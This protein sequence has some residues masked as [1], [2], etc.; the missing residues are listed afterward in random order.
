MAHNLSSLGILMV[1]MTGS[2]QAFAAPTTTDV[3]ASAGA[4]ATMTAPAESPALHAPERDDGTPP[5]LFGQHLAVGGYGGLDVAYT[6]MFGKDGSLVGLQGALLLDHRLSIGL[7]GYGWTDSEPG[8]LD[9]EGRPQSFNT[10]YGG[11][12]LRY[13]IFF[14]SPIYVTVGA[15]FGGGVIDLNH[16]HEHEEYDNDDP[17][18]LEDLFAVVQPDIT[19][20]A[21]L[22]SWMRVGINAGY[23]FTADVDRSGFEEADLNGVVVGGQLQFGHF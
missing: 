18:H 9:T 11:V 14:N 8:P 7:A 12:T 22:T 19:L 20:N 15:L 10:G 4:A 21:N 5:S 6:R 23:R 1:V 13:S 16:G 17:N 2:V 3:D